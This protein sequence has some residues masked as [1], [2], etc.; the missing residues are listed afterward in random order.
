MRRR[1]D[2][3]LIL[4]T[5]NE[6]SAMQF[7]NNVNRSSFR[8]SPDKITVYGMKSWVK[9]TNINNIYK[10]K[11]HFHFPAANHLDYYTP[12]MVAM[13]RNYRTKYGTDMS[14]VAVQGYD[15]LMYFCNSFFLK[16]QESRL[17]MNDFKLVQISPA[18]GFENSNI[19]IVKQEDFQLM[20][21]IW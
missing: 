6:K 10:N 14:R 13:N 3:R 21:I 15:V 2:L 12:F 17:L 5:N 8:A 4:P 18:D 11:Y 7:M 20:R 16:S 19:F 1:A 9:F